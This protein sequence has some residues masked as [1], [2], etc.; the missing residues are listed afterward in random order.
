M[1]L[2]ILSGVAYP[3]PGQTYY[4]LVGSVHVMLSAIRSRLEKPGNAQPML[5]VIVCQNEREKNVVND[6]MEL[7]FP[8]DP[9]AIMEDPLDDLVPDE[10]QAAVEE[11]KI[12]KKKTKKDK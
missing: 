9:D 1:A 6:L 3:I 2:P 7:Y 8:H 12:K 10:P 4:P 11:K 5:I